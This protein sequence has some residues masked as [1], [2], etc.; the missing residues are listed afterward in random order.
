[1]TSDQYRLLLR[2]KK[3]RCGRQFEARNMGMKQDVRGYWVDE[4]NSRYILFG[5]CPCGL[6]TPFRNLGIPEAEPGLCLRAI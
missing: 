2:G 5:H 4:F 6:V 1:M 3:C